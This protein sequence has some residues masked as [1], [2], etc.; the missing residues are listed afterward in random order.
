MSAGLQEYHLGLYLDGN[1][2]LLRENQI[3]FQ[4]QRGKINL[5]CCRRRKGIYICIPVKRRYYFEQC[6][7]FGSVRPRILPDSDPIIVLYRKLY[8]NI[9]ASFIN[10]FTNI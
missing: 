1:L 9:T 8:L 5:F 3:Q 10:V 7:G 2:S 4:R 6:L